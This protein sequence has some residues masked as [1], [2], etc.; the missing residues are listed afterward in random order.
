[1]QNIKSMIHFLRIFDA[2]QINEQRL[3]AIFAPEDLEIIKSMY[4]HAIITKDTKGIIIL[5]PPGKFILFFQNHIEDIQNF[6]NLLE[7]IG[8][9]TNYLYDYIK[10]NYY[11][12]SDTIGIFDINNYE[13]YLERIHTKKQQSKKVLLNNENN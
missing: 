8:I 3:K 6:G 12:E 4:T 1:M 5:T 13:K 9:D 7:S 2:S 11:S 10:N